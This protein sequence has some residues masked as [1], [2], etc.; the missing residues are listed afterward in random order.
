MRWTK[1]GLIFQPSRHRVLGDVLDAP[2]EFAHS[3]QALVCRD[4][5]RVFFSTR[6]REPGGT[7]RSHIAFV[8]F[9]RELKNV[10]RGHGYHLD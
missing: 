6:E 10:L 8:D 3:P 4:H 9:D 2:A 1:R 5:V 7:F